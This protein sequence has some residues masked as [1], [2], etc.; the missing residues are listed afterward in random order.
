MFQLTQGEYENLKSQ[1]ATSSWGGVRKLP[2]AFTENGI[3]MLSSV[4]TSERAIE[5][6]IQIMRTFTKLR[7]IL[8]THKDLREKIIDIEKKL[9]IHDLS[10]E[11]VFEAIELM[12]DQ[13]KKRVKDIGF[14][15][16]E[17]P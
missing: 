7:E 15:K 11:R 13:P 9:V 12:L 10:I 3:A 2:F 17:K 16:P 1:N 6:N 5:I 4:L 8:N 14:I